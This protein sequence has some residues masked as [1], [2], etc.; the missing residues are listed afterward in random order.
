MAVHM[1]IPHTHIP[2]GDAAVGKKKYKDIVPNVVETIQ[3]GNTTI[4]FCD[5]FLPKDPDELRKNEQEL[6]H[7]ARMLLNKIARK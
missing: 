5:N 3:I 7:T 1:A 2:R 4:R 6:I